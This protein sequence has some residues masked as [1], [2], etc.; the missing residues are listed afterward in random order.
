MQLRQKEDDEQ[1][2]QGEIQERH[3]V[4]LEYI[5][6]GHELRQVLL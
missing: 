2:K 1:L 5:A 4:E 6:W 3:E